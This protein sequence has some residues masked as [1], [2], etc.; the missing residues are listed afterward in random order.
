MSLLRNLST[1]AARRAWRLGLKVVWWIFL[2]ALAIV[3]GFTLYAVSVLPPLMPWH[4]ERLHEEFS[5]LRHGDLDFAG[6][7][8]LEDRLFADC[9]APSR[10]GTAPTRPGWRAVSTRRARSAAWPPAPPTT[11]RSA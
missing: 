5:A 8:Q 11:A 7:Q 10:P 6:Y 1:V 4:S 2:L 9:A 3:L